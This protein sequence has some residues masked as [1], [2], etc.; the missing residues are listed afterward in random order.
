MSYKRS[1]EPIVWLRFAGG[2][3]VSAILWPAVLVVL[4]L[5]LPLDLLTTD[6]M[7]YDRILHL[8]SGWLGRLVWL[9]L[10]IFPV[11]HALHRIYHLSKDVKL[12]NPNFM[13][14]LCYGLAVVASVSVFTLV[15]AL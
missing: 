12:G 6:A 3:M 13:S 15:I 10:I 4:I 14:V 7:S 11:W 2:G 1:N 9:T 8:S 5:F